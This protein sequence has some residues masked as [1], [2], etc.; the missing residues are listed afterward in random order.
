MLNPDCQEIDMRY[1]EELEVLPT[2]S[3]LDQ[4]PSYDEFCK[5]ISCL[6][7]RKTP[8]SDGIPAEVYKYAGP[9]IQTR[10]FELILKVWETE[11]VPQLWKDASIC[12]LYKG[13][14][15]LSLC[16]SYRGISLLNVAGKILSHIINKRLGR[17]AEQI[18]PE[19]QCG[20]RTNRGTSDAIFVVKQLQE[21]SLEQHRDLYLCF[22]DLEKRS[23]E[24]RE[25]RSG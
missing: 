16:D 3:D 14:G 4:S 6:K 11:T 12:K 13:K 22:V 21:K 25:L 1:I 7:N 8:G 10:L 20:F 19:S 5:A 17:I 9:K 15:N 24:S 23:I 18:L 2:V